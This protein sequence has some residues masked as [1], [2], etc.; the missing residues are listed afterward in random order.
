MLERVKATPE[1]FPDWLLK[2]ERLYFRIVQKDPSPSLYCFRKVVPES[3]RA[4]VLYDCHDKA[5]SAHFGINKTLIR[6]KERY[7]W[8]NMYQ[9]VTRYTRSCETCHM[10]KASHEKKR[11]HMGKFRFAKVPFQMISMDLVDPLPRSTR[12]NTMIFV[13]TDW[14]TKYVSIFPIRQA[15]AANIVHILENDIFLVYG[16]PEKVIMDNGEQ[17]VSKEMTKLIK[18]ILGG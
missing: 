7:F 4:Q 17:F 12:Q 18:K 6:V 15:T 3:Q 2:N 14:F 16:V 11:G 9:D 10:S 13:I 1:N 5:T 8:P